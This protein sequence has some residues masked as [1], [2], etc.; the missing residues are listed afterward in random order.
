[1]L[2]EGHSCIRTWGKTLFLSIVPI[3]HCLSPPHEG[4]TLQDLPAHVVTHEGLGA[5]CCPE[6]RHSREL[7]QG[8]SSVL[9]SSRPTFPK[10]HTP[11]RTPTPREKAAG[12]QYYLI[13][14]LFARERRNN[15]SETTVS[16]IWDHGC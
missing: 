5:L 6:D 3:S 12:K 7:H 9:L 4:P 11:N 15:R 1:M 2:C 16:W 14:Q 13:G 8:T 10:G